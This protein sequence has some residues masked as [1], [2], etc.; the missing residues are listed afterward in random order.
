[1]S[2]SFQKKNCS[3]SSVAVIYLSTHY[4][5]LVPTGN[6]RPSGH[7]SRHNKVVGHPLSTGPFSHCQ[8]QFGWTGTTHGCHATSFVW[9]TLGAD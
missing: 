8:R 3:D 2:C 4:A 7:L 5:W 6:H 1:M 9:V